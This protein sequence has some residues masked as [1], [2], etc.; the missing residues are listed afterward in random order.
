MVSLEEIETRAVK[1][2]SVFRL[3]GRGALSRKQ[4]ERAAQPLGDRWETAFVHPI[5][6]KPQISMPVYGQ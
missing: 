6:E 4:A 5:S 2:A 3:P 1:V